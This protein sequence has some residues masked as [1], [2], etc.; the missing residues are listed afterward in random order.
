MS[1]YNPSPP[2]CGRRQDYRD[3]VD[4]VDQLIS[5]PSICL[6][7]MNMLS[8]PHST[9]KDI[10]RVIVQDPPL[11]AQ[12]LRMANSPFYG[13]R[14][15]V[16]SLSRAVSVIGTKR[17][18]NLV[19]AVSAIKS[20]NKLSNGIVSIENFWQHSIYTGLIANILGQHSIIRQ[21]D[22]IF[23]AGLLHDIGQLIIF[24]KRP[25]DVQ[26][27]LTLMQ[28]SSSD[29]ELYVYEREV[30]GFDHMQVGAE[31]ARRWLL[32]DNLITCIEYHHCPSLASDHH[33]EV[34]LVYL[35]NRLA[36][37]AELNSIDLQDIP[38]IATKMWEITGISPNAVVEVLEQAQTQ[39]ES[40]QSI[41]LS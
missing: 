30:M 7:I 2:P 13:L 35:A 15:Q 31:L 4:D 32:P 6:K 34:A 9:A 25:D 19:I 11:T 37:L 8:D 20:F 10:E 14:S 36:A 22:S 24:N 5:L 27:A 29:T 23:I 38:P 41:L 33:L 26:I 28:D 1:A 16:D 12:L 3:M 39:F 21:N 40:A 18:N 17:I